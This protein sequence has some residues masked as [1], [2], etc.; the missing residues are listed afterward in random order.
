[1]ILTKTQ[2][3][4]IKTNLRKIIS[5]MKKY[6]KSNICPFNETDIAGTGLQLHICYTCA[7]I[8]GVEIKK[9]EYPDCPCEIAETGIEGY[10]LKEAEDLL[11]VFPS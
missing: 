8:R 6:G 7:T 9:D 4:K 5:D 2:C 10:A 1:M 3:K 11:E